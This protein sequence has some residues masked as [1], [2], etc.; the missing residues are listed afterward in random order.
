M[1]DL[2]RHLSLEKL[3]KSTVVIFW[4]LQ[5]LCGELDDRLTLLGYNPGAIR[6]ISQGNVT[7]FQHMGL[8]DDFLLLSGVLLHQP[9]VI[10]LGPH[11]IGSLAWLSN[12]QT[13]SVSNSSL[14]PT[15]L[16]TSA[17]LLSTPRRYSMVKLN[18]ARDATQ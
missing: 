3:S 7:V 9:W 14:S 18:P 10:S 15:W 12:S 16:S 17:T 4:M 11:T 2:V 8:H 6:Q 1:L 5:P 13:E